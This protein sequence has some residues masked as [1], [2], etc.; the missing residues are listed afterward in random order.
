MMERRIITLNVSKS[1]TKNN[2]EIYTDVPLPTYVLMKLFSDFMKW[3]M[4]Y[5]VGKSH[6]KRLEISHEL[7]QS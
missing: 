1:L 6:V 4:F 5:C 3:E 2:F 7:W